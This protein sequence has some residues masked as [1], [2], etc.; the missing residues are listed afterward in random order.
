MHDDQNDPSDSPQGVCDEGT[1]AQAADRPGKA[2]PRPPRLP[3]QIA[4]DRAFIAAELVKGRSH[5]DIADALNARNRAE[6]RGYEVSRSTVTRDSWECVKVWREEHAADIERLRYREL[7][8]LSKQE[9]EL[10]AAWERSKT[11]KVR[12]LVA[13]TSGSGEGAG[14]KRR[15]RTEEG[16]VGDPSFMRLLLE[17]RA[18]RIRMLG[19][20]APIRTEIGGPDGEPISLRGGAPTT[21]IVLPAKDPLPTGMVDRR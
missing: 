11:P 13:E 1:I 19:L 3:S 4:S 16:A 14:G 2:K 15:Q 17:V 10:W 21:V 8:G 18:Q 12:M 20:E 5:G 9:E 6:G 7:Y